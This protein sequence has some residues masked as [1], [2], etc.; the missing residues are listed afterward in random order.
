MALIAES[1]SAED[2]A[3]DAMIASECAAA[4]R[5]SSLRG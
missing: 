1:M 3:C 4:T 5:S 2:F